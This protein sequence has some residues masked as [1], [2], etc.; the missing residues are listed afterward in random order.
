[1][2]GSRESNAMAAFR[3]QAGIYAL[4]FALVFPVFFLL[5]YGL[6][7]FGIVATV[8][9]SLTMAAEEGARASLRYFLPAGAASAS[10]Q[11]QALGRLAHGCDVAT[12]RA[13]WLGQLGG[14]AAAPSCSAVLRGPCRQAD[15][16]IDASQTCTVTLG[17][18]GGS[19][20]ACGYAQAEQCFAILTMSF[21]YGSNPLVPLLPGMGLLVPDVLRAVAQAAIDPA[22]LR[23]ASTGGGA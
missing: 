5:F 8:Q 20:V 15:G 10:A 7:S 13:G 14:A 19:A 11:Q 3:R 6:L 4:E 9:Q 21:A 2:D 16:T 22:T 18:G 12:Y 17:S 23:L 1:M